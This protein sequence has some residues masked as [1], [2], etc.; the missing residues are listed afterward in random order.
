ME[1]RAGQCHEV[2][3]SSRCAGDSD[4]LSSSVGLC[5]EALTFLPAGMTSSVPVRREQLVACDDVALKHEPG[6]FN[7]YSMRRCSAVAVAACD[8]VDV[9]DTAGRDKGPDEWAGGAMF[10][11][12]S[13]KPGRISRSE[14]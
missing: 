8:E 4:L 3:S 6:R 13:L 9:G 1:L 12:I 10:T 11:Q 14:V 2:G 7:A 5:N